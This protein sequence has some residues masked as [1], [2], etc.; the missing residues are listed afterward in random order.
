MAGST[1][2]LLSP[3]RGLTLTPVASPLSSD[4]LQERRTVRMKA[5]HLVRLFG[6]GICAFV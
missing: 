6:L 5:H 4:N 2:E 1:G 3:L